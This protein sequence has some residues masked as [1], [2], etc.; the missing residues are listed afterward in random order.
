MSKMLHINFFITL[1]FQ[2]YTGPPYEL[3]PNIRPVVIVGPAL[4]GFEV[5]DMM[6]KALFDSLKKAFEGRWVH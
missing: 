3:V 6:Q 2:G 4:K 1:F 5:T